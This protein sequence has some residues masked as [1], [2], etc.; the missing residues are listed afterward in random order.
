MAADG[1]YG[2][3]VPYKSYAPYSAAVEAEAT[4]IQTG[5]KDSLAFSYTLTR[6]AASIRP[7]QHKA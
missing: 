6:G 1:S 3:Y 2:T 4:K 7:R 5:K